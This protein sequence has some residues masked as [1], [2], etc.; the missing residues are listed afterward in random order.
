MGELKIPRVKAPHITKKRPPTEPME[1]NR[2]RQK[3]Q[4]RDMKAYLR[5][6]P[7]HRSNTLVETYTEG[8]AVPTGTRKVTLQGTYIMPLCILCGKK[9][10][11]CICLEGETL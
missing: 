9:E 2:A 5:G 8:T 6:F 10:K 1:F 4:Q 11:K 7:V 3:A